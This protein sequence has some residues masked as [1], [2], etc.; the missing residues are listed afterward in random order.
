M[1]VPDAG[2]ARTPCGVVGRRRPTIAAQVVRRI[3]TKANGYVT[4]FRGRRMGW[5][6]QHE[7]GWARELSSVELY[8]LPL[9]AAG[10]SVRLNGRVYEALV[11]RLER[12][13]SFDLYHSA[14]VVWVPEGRFVIEQAPPACEYSRSGNTTPAST[15]FEE[16]L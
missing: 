8:W 16:G 3:R 12:R 13:T 9:G 11:A 2:R 1:P 15:Q 10:H 14:L 6:V 4:Y 7:A 5:S